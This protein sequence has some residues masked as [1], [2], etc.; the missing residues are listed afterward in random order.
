[1][2]GAG[3]G[4]VS[5][6]GLVVGVASATTS[7]SV[8]FTAGLAGILAGTISMAAGEY[9]S[10]SSQKDSEKALLKEERHALRT[11]PENELQEL[12]SIYEAKGLRKNTAM[13][14]AKELT[15]HDAFAAHFDAE[16]RIDPNNLT[17]PHHAAYASASSFLIGSIIPLIAILLPPENIRIPV[18]FISV[19]AALAITGVF[20]AKVGGA[21]VVRATVRVVSGGV[22]AMVVTYIIGQI[23]QVSGI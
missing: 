11:H 13:I 19:I 8:I 1:M 21:N 12:A 16:L 18:T 3:D 20:S 7:F 14:V 10:V 17:N 5:T 23:F 22:I 6:A 4:I 15:A 2:L 9:V